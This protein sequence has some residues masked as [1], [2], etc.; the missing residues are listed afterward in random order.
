MLALLRHFYYTRKTLLTIS[1]FR[2]EKGANTSRVAL[3]TNITKQAKP[4]K[5]NYLR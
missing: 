3:R 2:I 4:P 5:N 1:G